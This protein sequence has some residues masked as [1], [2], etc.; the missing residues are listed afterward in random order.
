[1]HYMHKETIQHTLSIFKQLSDFVSP[2]V[3]EDIRKEMSQAL[4]QIEND[5][6]LPL[7]ELEET[8]IVFGKKVWP[9]RKAYIELLTLQEGKVG[10]KFLE[11]KLSGKM[12]KKFHDFK[13]SGGTMRDLHTGRKID[14]FDSKERAELCEVLVDLANELRSNTAQAIN[15]T[16]QKKFVEKV[17]DFS[18]ILEDLEHRLESLRIMAD[19]EQEH[20][21]LASEIRDHVRAFE[22]GM[23]ALGPELSYEALC[24]ASEHFTGRKEHLK[25]RVNHTSKK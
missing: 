7:E 22:L 20:P 3:P 12:K 5:L 2:I 4:E 16:K 23:C 1:M 25:K 18:D 8:M 13:K 21:Q 14:F 11:G 17:L 10:E 24:S 9:Y 19:A 6:S 15:S